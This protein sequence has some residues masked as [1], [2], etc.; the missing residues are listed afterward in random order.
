MSELALQLA[1]GAIFCVTFGLLVLE[2]LEKIIVGLGAGIILVLFG[3]VEF[4]KATLSIDFPCH[5]AS[6]RD[7]APSR[8]VT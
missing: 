7:D 3:L 8:D 1:V 4:D 5:R 6:L 2:K